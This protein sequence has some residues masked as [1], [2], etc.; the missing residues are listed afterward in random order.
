MR[1]VNLQS[2]KVIKNNFTVQIKLSNFEKSKYFI[3]GKNK[4]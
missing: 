2:W 3:S 4:I 1:N